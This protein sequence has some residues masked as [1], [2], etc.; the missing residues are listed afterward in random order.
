MKADFSREA[1]CPESRPRFAHLPPL[2]T[3]G[4][5]TFWPPISS[6]SDHEIKEPVTPVIIVP[7]PPLAPQERPESGQPAPIEGF[8]SSCRAGRPRRSRRPRRGA[9]VPG[10]TL[11][12]R[13]GRSLRAQVQPGIPAGPDAV[14]EAGYRLR[15]QAAPADPGSQ[16]SGRRRADQDAASSQGYRLAEVPFLE[17]DGRPLVLPK[18]H[19]RREAGSGRPPRPND[20]LGFG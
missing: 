1:G 7:P 5:Y 9:G 3:P 6:R 10:G 20:N 16:E 14:R 11:G 4:C 12:G 19:G 15:R 13:S 8:P 2:S 17:L 18:Q